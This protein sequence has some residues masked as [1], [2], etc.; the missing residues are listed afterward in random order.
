MFLES[1][2]SSKQCNRKILP[3]LFHAHCIAHKYLD[4]YIFHPAWRKDLAPY[5]CWKPHFSFPRQIGNRITSHSIFV[6]WTS[7]LPRLYL[8]KL[9][10]ACQGY[11]QA[12]WLK[13][14]SHLEKVFMPVQF[15]LDILLFLK[16]LRTTVLAVKN[17]PLTNIRKEFRSEMSLEVAWGHL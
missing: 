8:I 10:H 3:L 5:S 17:T 9:L 4:L 16:M 1:K 11:F 7:I 2:E 14:S 13:N 12:V 15:S 6:S